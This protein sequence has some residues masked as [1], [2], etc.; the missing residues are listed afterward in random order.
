MAQTVRR[1]RYSRQ[2][3]TARWSPT[4]LDHRQNDPQRFLAVEGESVRKF[5]RNDGISRG[6][7]KEGVKGGGARS[8]GKKSSRH[9]FVARTIFPLDGKSESLI[10]EPRISRLF[11]PLGDPPAQGGTRETGTSFWISYRKARYVQDRSLFIAIRAY[12][13]IR[14]NWRIFRAARH[15]IGFRCEREYRTSRLLVSAREGKKKRDMC[16]GKQKIPLYCRI[17]EC[18]GSPES[19]I[20]HSRVDETAEK[21]QW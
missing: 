6:G 3:R 12:S 9:G 8:L 20:K 21:R 10:R 1:L 19:L 5:Y 13:E 4:N 17:V 16:R 7:K 18:G 14:S 11:Y 2:F 15:S